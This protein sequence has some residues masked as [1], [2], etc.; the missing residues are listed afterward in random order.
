MDLLHAV[1]GGVLDHQAQIAALFHLCTLPA[2][3]PDGP[4]ALGS[5]GIQ[6]GGD[7][8]RSARHGQ[9]PDHVARLDQPLHLALET[10]FVSKVIA[11][12]REAGAVGGQ[13]HRRE[14]G[15]VS[16]FEAAH[17]FGGDVLSVGGAAP[18]AQGV[19]PLTVLECSDDRLGGVLEDLRRCLQRLNRLQVELRGL[20]LAG[21]I[22][23]ASLPAGIPANYS[24]VEER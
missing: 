10:H 8:G 22:P 23:V 12:G 5:G 19:Q 7:V 20:A 18:V 15:P 14:G 11:D 6:C 9:S 24:H 1:A 3:E 2:G 4:C 17:E 21:Q 13:G 16:L